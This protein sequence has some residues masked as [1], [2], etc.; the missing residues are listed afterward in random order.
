MNIIS[1]RAELNQYTET[2]DAEGNFIWKSTSDFV[3]VQSTS[4]GTIPIGHAMSMEFDFIWNGPTDVDSSSESEMFFRIG[5]SP[6]SNHCDG[7]WNR[8]PAL[9]ITDDDE[10]EASL[11]LYLSEEGHCSK[12]YDLS[13]LGTIEQ[14]ISYHVLISFNMTT[15]RVSIG[16]QG[17]DPQTALWTRKGTPSEFIGDD[18]PVWW[19]SDKFGTSQYEP[20][21]GIFSNIIITSTVLSPEEIANGQISP[22]NTSTTTVPPTTTETQTTTRTTVESASTTQIPTEITTKVLTE[23]PTV[24]ATQKAT[25]T[26][27]VTSFMTESTDSHHTVPTNPVIVVSDNEANTEEEGSPFIVAQM[28]NTTSSINWTFIAMAVLLALLCFAT[29]CCMAWFGVA[30]LQRKQSQK[31]LELSKIADA[32]S[33]TRSNRMNRSKMPEPRS[34]SSDTQIS[35]TGTTTVHI[36]VTSGDEMES[37]P[38]TDAEGATDNEN[39]DEEKEGTMERELTILT[40][41]REETM[42][43]VSDM[44]RR[45]HSPRS[46]SLSNQSPRFGSPKS[47]PRGSS[48]RRSTPRGSSPRFGGRRKDRTPT[49][50]SPRHSVKVKT[51]IRGTKG[52]CGSDVLNLSILGE[53]MELPISPPSPLD[54]ETPSPMDVAETVRTETPRSGRESSGPYGLSNSLRKWRTRGN[55]GDMKVLEYLNERTRGD[56]MESFK[57]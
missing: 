49:G 24:I 27:A 20:A 13:E 23:T 38:G 15:L 33:P 25:D 4:Y 22:I 43:S 7:N 11:V 45:E 54:D 42:S 31:E 1:T 9:F 12:Y 17:V 52:Q 39:D 40:P 55:S 10:E 6:V 34:P 18:V 3:P 26:A 51:H 21:D 16:E 30:N 5:A 50:S 8:Y 46:V 14:N 32:R 35:G 41:G 48:P 37:G 29:G 2:T 53:N 56:T 36:I 47:T 28:G 57:E 44:Y 19:M